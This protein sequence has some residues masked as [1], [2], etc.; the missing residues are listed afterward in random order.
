MRASRPHIDNL[1]LQTISRNVYHLLPPDRTRGAWA[2]RGELPLRNPGNLIML[3]SLTVEYA[4]AF[5]GI[6]PKGVV[7]LSCTRTRAAANT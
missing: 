2:N 5:A 6:D 3:E 4:D 7:W 1:H